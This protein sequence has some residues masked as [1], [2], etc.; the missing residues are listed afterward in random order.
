MNNSVCVFE[1]DKFFNFLPLVY[2]RPVYN[3]RCGISQLKEK[4]F[5]HFNTQDKILFCREYLSEKVKYE[6]PKF[7]VNELKGDQIIF[8]NGRL[9]ITN[10]IVQELKKQKEDIIYYC[11]DSVA[12]AKISKKNFNLIFEKMPGV[13]SFQE[14]SLKSMRIKAKLLNY[15]WDIIKVNGEQIT[16]DYKVLTKKNK[17]YINKKYNGVYFINKK[18]IFIGANTVIYPT[19]VIDASE[20]PVYIGSNV[21]ILPHAAIEG[22]AFIGDN[23]LIK[24]KASIYANSSIGEVCKIG[25]EIENT[26]FQSYSN[27][28]HD[29]FLGHSYIGS[30][31][32]LGADTTSSDLKNNYSKVSVLLNNKS[33]DTGMQFLGLMM[34]DH[35]KTGINTMFNTGTVVG[36]SSNIY[37]SGFPPKFVPSFAWGSPNEFVTYDLDKSMH[38]AEIVMARRNITFNQIDKKIFQKIYELT[39]DERKSFKNIA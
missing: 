35:S 2:N 14:L 29:G 36:F 39:Q 16:A 23:S 28:Q 22:P 8:I 17:N 30:F 24:M 6:N 7:H 9:L 21:K 12:A 1:D 4:I 26:I 31:V 20:G 11:E 15:I 32:N 25:G 18:E 37:G 3:L 13:L 19:V 27:K 5:R 10:D 33:V 38:T 34:G